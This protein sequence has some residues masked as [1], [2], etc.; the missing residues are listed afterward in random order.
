[1]VNESVLQLKCSCNNYPWGKTGKDSIAAR[2]CAGTPNTDFKIE[3]D[4]DYAEM[5]MG[6][7]PEL[8]SYVLETGENLQDVINANKEQLI[9]STILERFGH[10]DLVFLPKVLSIAKALPLQLHPNKELSS[11]LHKEDPKNFTDPNHKP[12]IALALGDFEAFVGFKPL[13]EIEKLLHMEPLKKFIINGGEFDDRSLK[14]TVHAI[15]TADDDVIAET[16]A[17]LKKLD[18]SVF[19]KGNE[20]IPKMIPRLWEQYDKTVSLQQTF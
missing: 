20:Y 6:T 5:W 14:K 12:E 11:K 17:A 9:G 18:P 2:L 7:Y 16:G 13:A 15:L 19:G 3:D 4:K 1:M 10:S 8:P